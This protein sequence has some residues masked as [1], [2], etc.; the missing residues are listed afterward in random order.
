LS[1]CGGVTD[2][3]DLASLL[4][5]GR[6]RRLPRQA[7]RRRR[8]PGEGRRRWRS[9]RAGPPRWPPPAG[10]WAWRW[11]QAAATAGR[12]PSCRRS[13]TPGRAPEAPAERRLFAALS[14]PR[15]PAST[16]SSGRH[17]VARASDLEALALTDGAGR[18][19]S[20]RWSAWPPTR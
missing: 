3:A 4:A 8:R 18:R 15:S 17:A 1:L 20:T 2:P 5:S 10:C 16:A 19:P 11:V 14:R 6:A 9:R 7:R 13:S 12:S